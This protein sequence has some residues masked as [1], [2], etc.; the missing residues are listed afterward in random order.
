M[1]K[2]ALC[3]HGKGVCV[4]CTK[5]TAVCVAQIDMHSTGFRILKLAELT[6]HH[7]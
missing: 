4:S 5:K 2:I 1:L 3:G 6:L 7:S